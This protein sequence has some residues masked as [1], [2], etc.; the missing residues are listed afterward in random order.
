MK[1]F[2]LQLAAISTVFLILCIGLT[3]I[4]F[5]DNF[6][7]FKTLD[8]PY[9]KVAW[10]LNLIENSPDLIKGKTIFLGSS[11]IQGGINDSILSSKG[12][13]SINMGVPHNGNDLNLYFFDRIKNLQPKEVVWLKG[14]VKY[15]GLHKLTPLLYKPSSILSNGQGINSSFIRYFFKRVKLAMEYLQFAVF[16]YDWKPTEEQNRFLEQSYGFIPAP[17]IVSKEVFEDYKNGSVSRNDEYY[18]LYLNDYTY[19]REKLGSGPNLLTIWRRR[20][21]DQFYLRSNFIRN[22]GSQ[23]GFIDRAQAASLNLN[24]PFHKI[25]I[26]LLLDASLEQH[27]EYDRQFYRSSYSD[28]KEPINLSSYQFLMQQSYWSDVDHVSSEGAEILTRSYFK[29]LLKD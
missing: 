10:N 22:V 11:L 15:T 21:I 6:I 17:G 29:F 28:K 16:R 8:T 18:N 5:S 1:R 25:Y 9:K 2:L 12:L 13:P 26:P 24:I 4:N 7:F 27:V 23:E 19:L 14:K 3:S 20:L